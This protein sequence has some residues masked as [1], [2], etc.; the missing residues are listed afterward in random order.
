MR[1]LRINW[2]I[3]GG[4]GE[5]TI[6]ILS[7]LPFTWKST[8]ALVLG[9]LLAKWFWILFAPH[10]IFTAA[11]PER[12]AGVEADQLFGRVQSNESATQGVA[13]PNVKLLGIFS[14]N[15]GKTGFAILKLDDKLQ[16]GVAEGEEVTP[17]TKLVTVFT[18]HVLLERAGVQQQVSLENKYAS[19]PNKGVLPA[20]TPDKRHVAQLNAGREYCHPY[21]F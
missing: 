20:N 5:A 11:V 15:A 16:V 7:R 18:D 2:G 6:V 13:L 10:A 1:I 8:S 19:S 14:A 3:F 12:A 4:F 21:I 17:G 9:V